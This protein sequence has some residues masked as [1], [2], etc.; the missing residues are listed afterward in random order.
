LEV[1]M[2]TTM[3]IP[4]QFDFHKKRHHV[5]AVDVLRIMCS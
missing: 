5:V 1:I 2:A 3:S 4:H